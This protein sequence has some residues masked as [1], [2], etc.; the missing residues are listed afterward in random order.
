MARDRY[1]QIRLTSDEM[2]EIKKRA[3][4]I[5][6]S[7]FLR[8]LAL[9]Q[10]VPQPSPKPT[11]IVYSADPELVREVNRIGIN[12]NQIAKHANE[13]QEVSNAVLIA[14]LNLQASLDK[15]LASS[16]PDDR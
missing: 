4:G 3:G 13:G 10:P 2:A 5:T 6:T 8:Q 16:M 15:A 1:I 7:S 12:I 9:E 11:K 14:L